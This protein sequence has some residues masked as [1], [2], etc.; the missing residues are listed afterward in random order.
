MSF[1]NEHLPPLK[2]FLSENLQRT[3]KFSRLFF[4]ASVAL[5]VVL[6]LTD[7]ATTNSILEEF[8]EIVQEAGVIDETTGKLSVFVLLQNNWM[9]MLSTV[10][11][12]FLPFLL[13]PAL[14]LFSN[15]VL[16]G[17]LAGMYLTT[18]ELGISLFLAG[19]L[20]HGIFEIPA[21]LL[22]SACGIYLCLNASL[23]LC[24]RPCINLVKLITDLLRV[25]LLVIAPL[26]IA[27]AFIECYVTP[28]IMALFQ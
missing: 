25:L 4:I 28:L 7:P 16:L 8:S 21:M 9:A 5:G 27:A 23:F 18:G 2:V 14:S 15:G 19:I 12:G 11:F 26:T 1:L 22:S 17:V 3:R 13:L 10:I 6:Y 20:P 24:K